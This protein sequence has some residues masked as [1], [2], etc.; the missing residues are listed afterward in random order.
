MSIALVQPSLLLNSYAFTDVFGGCGM[1]MDTT[2]NCPKNTRT[3]DIVNWILYAYNHTPTKH[4]HHVVLH[5]HGKP[6]K[7][8]I[9]EAAAEVFVPGR[10]SDY[11]EAKYIIIDWINAGMF[12]ALKGKNIGTIWL[13]SCSVAN[14]A[15]GKLLCRKLAEYSGCKVVAPEVDQE[16]WAAFLNVMFMP[17]GSI[18]DFEGQVYMWDGK[19]NMGSFNPNG[20]NWT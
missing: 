9:G 4:L 8:L 16:R 18:D 19:G 11:K 2:W 15:D 7:L 1:S 17:K 3:Q 13:H 5:F 14:G 10:P 12:G 20:G 6:G